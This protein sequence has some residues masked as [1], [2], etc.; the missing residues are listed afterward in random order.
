VI[1]VFSYGYDPVVAARPSGRLD[2]N[3][4]G[5]E[6]SAHGVGQCLFANNCVWLLCENVRCVIGARAVA[7]GA[8]LQR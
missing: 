2:P 1:G 3:A 4:V 7:D 8:A 6:H 5:G